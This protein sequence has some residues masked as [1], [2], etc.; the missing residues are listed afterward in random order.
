ML[1]GDDALQALREAV[2]LSP[3]N[4]PLRQHLADTLLAMGRAEEAEKEYREALR[5]A[6]DNARLKVGLA[7]VFY[8]EGKL[9]E[10]LVLVEALLKSPST[11][12]RAYLLHARLLL[13]AGDVRRAV[14]QYR[15]A[16]EADPS[17]ADAELAG[18]LGIGAGDTSE[19]VEGKGRAAWEEPGAGPS[20][21]VEKPTVTF[22]DVGGMDAL[23]DEIRMKIIY[24]L[25]QP[26][27]YRAYG[28]A[29]GGGILMYGPPGCGKTHLARATAGEVQAGFLAVGIN[30]VLEMWIGQSER[31]LHELFEQARS[32]RPCV[33]FFDEVDALGAS[34]S[35]MRHSAGRQLINQ[36]LAE[37]DGIKGENEGVLILAATNAPWHLDSAFRR[38]GRFDRI[39]FVPPPDGPARAA[40]LR[41][42]SRGKPQ[43]ALDFDYLAKKTDGF[44]GADLKAVVDVAVEKKLREAFKSGVPQPLTT[45]DLLAAAGTIRPSTKEWFATAR[46]YALYANQ[47]GLYDDILKYLKL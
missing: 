8:Q 2:R 14:L 33:L 41:I 32:H 46:N 16:V 4:M 45:K 13:Q 11:P 3:G 21:D 29:V 35:D 27:L 22:K 6:P 24:P 25:S 31:N 20:A 17:V 1:H 34:R 23:K 12:A 42:L 40:I 47:G 26:E 9:S 15:E 7:S 5:L 28:K 19:V 10:A 37:L 43:D 18:R 38:P 30:D 39:L 36:F 44:S